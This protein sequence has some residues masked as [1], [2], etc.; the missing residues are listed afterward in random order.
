MQENFRLVVGVDIG[1]SKVRVAAG[2]LNESGEIVISG[3]AEVENSGMS[4]GEI[5]KIDAPAAAIDKALGEVERMSG[6]EVN[7]ATVS[8]NGTSILSTNVS[9]MIAVA[10]S[11]LG[12]QDEDVA[13]LEEVASTGKVPVNRE[14]LSIIAHEYILDGQAGIKDPLGMVGSRL[15]INANVV[16]ALSPQLHSL[17]RACEQAHL[18][19]SQIIVSVLAA[20]EAVLDEGQRENGVAVVDFGHATTSVAI[21]EEGDLRHVAVI[22]VGGRHLTNDL[23]TMLS[24]TPDIAEQIKLAHA[25]AISRKIDKQVSIKVDRKSYDF[26][27][28]QVDEAV[29][30]RLEELFELIREQIAR[31]GYEGRLPNGL[32]LVGG[33]SNLRELAKFAKQQ[34]GMVAAV[35]KPNQLN[36]LKGLTEKVSDPAF[37]AAVG[38]MM[39]DITSPAESKSDVE[40]SAKSGLFT[41]FKQLFKPG[42]KS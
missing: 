12:V 15:D 18:V 1:T 40:A 38:L 24:V 33:G 10:D 16:S 29:G 19:P 5:T 37:A 25:S 22:P 11:N 17:Q 39:I 20:A 7:Q 26:S 4:K 23:A 35:A 21:F 32:V 34:L 28:H 8:L 27:L 31:A 41:K 2:S 6:L 3:V 9:G 14:I 42:A 13:R 36:Q 30:A